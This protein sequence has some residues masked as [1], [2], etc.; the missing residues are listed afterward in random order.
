MNADARTLS[1][2]QHLATAAELAA[3]GV[4]LSA[5][6]DLL[7]RARASL[8]SCWATIELETE[9]MRTIRTT[10]SERAKDGIPLVGRTKTAKTA[11]K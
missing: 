5:R 2:V 7:T 4:S 8:S 11:R 6:N 1:F 9:D 10:M 3:R